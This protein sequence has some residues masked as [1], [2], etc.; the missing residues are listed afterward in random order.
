MAKTSGGVRVQAGTINLTGG[1]G[2]DIVR[3]G[4]APMNVTPL[5]SIPDKRVLNQ[6][7]AVISKMFKKYGFEANT[8]AM[9]DL[10]GAHGVAYIGTKQVYL[11][12]N[13]FKDAKKLIASKKR[14]YESG[15]K[16]ITKNPLQHTLVHELAHIKWTTEMGGISKESESKVQSLFKQAKQEAKMLNKKYGQGAKKKWSLGSYALTNVNEFWAEA[17]TQY[18]IGRR[19]SKYSKEIGKIW[20]KEFKKKAGKATPTAGG[21]GRR[22]ASLFD[23]RR[24]K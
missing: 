10:D 11:N 2:K 23:K 21:R 14:E 13:G 16:T 22:Q 20:E 4:G 5:D 1:G 24:K 9:A 17:S 8:V 12:K 15:F 3:G 7:R 19:Q 6:Q 18:H